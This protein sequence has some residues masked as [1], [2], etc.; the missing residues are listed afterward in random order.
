MK[1]VGDSAV[2]VRVNAFVFS[3]S[4]SFSSPSVGIKYQ[5]LEVDL[6]DSVE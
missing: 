2:S 4:Q 1:G 6:H 3:W 5:S